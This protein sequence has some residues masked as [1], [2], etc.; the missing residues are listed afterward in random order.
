MVS[1]PS[2]KMPRSRTCCTGCTVSQPMRSS[3]FGSWCSRRWWAHHSTSVLLVL[4]CKRFDFIH[5]AT[6]SMQADTPSCRARTSDGRH[7]SVLTD[8]VFAVH[9][10]LDSASTLRSLY[11]HVLFGQVGRVN[12][13]P[14]VEY[15]K[16]MC[17]TC[18]RVWHVHLYERRIACWY[19]S[20]ADRVT[21]T[22][23][24]KIIAGCSR[25]RLAYCIKRQHHACIRRREAVTC[26]SLASPMWA[27]Y[28]NLHRPQWWVRFLCVLHYMPSRRLDSFITCWYSASNSNNIGW[29]C[30][31]DHHSCMIHDDNGW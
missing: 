8:S 11:Q 13:R 17:L 2:T 21:E 23:T 30:L 16:L 26:T 3:S 28:A 14:T 12:D 15:P 1:P 5:T 29:R 4:S 6:S 22:V 19:I 31:Q 25:W 18:W 20:M 24:D 10:G 9:Y 27:E 7:S